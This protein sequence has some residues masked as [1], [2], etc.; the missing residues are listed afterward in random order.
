MLFKKEFLVKFRY[1]MFLYV[2]LVL[3]LQQYRRLTVKFGGLF[4]DYF[5]VFMSAFCRNI[6]FSGKKKIAYKN[7]LKSLNLVKSELKLSGEDLEKNIKKLRPI[8]FLRKQNVGRRQVLIP[9]PL[10]KKGGLS[11]SI[12]WLNSVLN[13]SN[14][15]N[16][17][18]PIRFL[19]ELKLIQENKG[20]TLK[21]KILLYKSVISNRSNTRFLRFLKAKRY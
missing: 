14:K 5:S 18:F 12:R 2:L 3:K 17:N 10:E 1:F 16:L 7:L 15:N 20:E 4:S 21:K 9:L 19:E 13:K 6:M 11:K 8:F